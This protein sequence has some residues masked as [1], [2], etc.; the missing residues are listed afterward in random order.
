MISARVERD[1]IAVHGK[2]VTS[3]VLEYPR[4]IH[5]E[6]MTHRILSRNAASS[7]AI[8]ISK[9]LE[10][11]QHDPAMPL[12]WGRNQKG[13]SAQEEL[14]SLSV[15]QA[16]ENILELRDLALIRVGRLEQLNLHKQTSNRYVEPWMHMATV[17][18]GTE[19]ENFYHLRTDG[20]AQPEFRLLAEAMLAAHNASEPELLYPG[21]WHLPFVIDEEMSLFPVKLLRQFSVAR[22]ARV[23]YR[24]HDNVVVSHDRDV[25]RHAAL[26]EHKHVSPFEHQATPLDNNYEW[27]GNFQGWHQYRKELVGEHTTEFPRLIPKKGIRKR[28]SQCQVSL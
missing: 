21:E 3:F 6:V 1:S 4:F 9:M 22:C 19:W 15:E 23:S 28:S 7:R 11:I 2:R 24:T 8:P 14:D 25:E 26:F 20:E 17:M 27:S 16:A 5:S 18:T 13:M 10:R 12:Y